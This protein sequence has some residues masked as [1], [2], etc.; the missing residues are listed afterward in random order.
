[1]CWVWPMTGEDNF[2]IRP[3]RIRSTRAQR[4]GPSSRRRSPPRSG[5][6]GLALGKIDRPRPSL[7]LRQ[8]SA[9]IGQANRLITARSRGAVV[10]ARVVRHARAAP[11]APHLAICAARA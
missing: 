4:R 8:G 1:M 9:R 11:P 10:K 2:R 5:P 7:A 6:A 3:G